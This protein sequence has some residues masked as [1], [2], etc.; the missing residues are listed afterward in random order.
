ME[1][2][3]EKASLLQSLY[4]AQSIADKKATMPILG[5]VLLRTEGTEQ[6]MLAGTDLNITVSGLIPC[7]VSQ[8]G[9]VAVSAR[10][11]YDLVKALPGELIK[12]KKLDNHA[13][14]IQAAGTLYQVV[15]LPDADFP[16]L[17]DTAQVAFHGLD[18]GTLHDVIRKTL[19]SVST[20]E[21]RFHL[22]GALLETEPGES[23]TVRMVSTDGHR[24]SK[25]ERPWP[26]AP[27]LP[28][29][30]LIPRRG[31]LE[32]R[33]VIDGVVGDVHMGFWM[34]HLFLRHGRT[35]LC[36]KLQDAQFPPY[37]QVIPKG[38]QRTAVLSKD[39]LLQ[40]LRRISLMTSDKT[41]GV[42]L[43][44][45]ANELRVEADNPDVGRGQE[46]IAVQYKGTP[47]G[48]GFN[49]KYMIE[50]LNEIDTPEIRLELNGELEPGVIR[51]VDEQERIGNAYLGV[52]MPMR[53]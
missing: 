7:E 16:R 1:F 13:L 42:K 8:E 14:E 33:R 43:Q 38:Q 52:I 49:A 20:D 2:Q 37:A 34:G 44:I 19:F 50:L 46:R 31:L 3:V 26:G 21:T 25:C 15:G 17:P 30:V 6:L 32:L 24:L 22:N 27:K 12:C 47:L 51:P 40:A 36:V 9:G 41:W 45:A 18:A 53:I 4:L 39:A 48:I 5:H 29:T 10:T 35:T 23:G 28:G 11:L